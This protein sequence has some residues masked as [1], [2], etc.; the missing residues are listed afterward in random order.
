MTPQD[1]D[2]FD[3]LETTFGTTGW[4]ILV[5]EAK[6]KIY[7]YQA[8][9]LEVPTWEQVLILRGRAL[10]MQDFVDLQEVNQLARKTMLEQEAQDAP[11]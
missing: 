4:K 9:A 6:A 5:E 10:Q 2:Y 1:S 11:V 7:E 3:E 8:L